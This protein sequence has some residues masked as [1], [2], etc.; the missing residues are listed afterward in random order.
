M[1]IVKITP[2]GESIKCKAGQNGSFLF[3][4]SNAT[5][6]KV[7]FSAQTKSSGKAIDWLSIDGDAERSLDASATSTIE[8]AACPPANLLKMEEG[9]KRFNFKLRVHNVD[10]SKDTV[11][12]AT[13][14]VEVIP[15][16]P[17]PKKF[18]WWIVILLAVTGLT[19]AGIVIWLNQ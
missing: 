14:S 19:I 16:P 3:N 15:V 8:V 5:G 17:L 10:D 18:P 2:A 11:D 6:K 13:V 9:N 12:S 4:I 1:A 7:R